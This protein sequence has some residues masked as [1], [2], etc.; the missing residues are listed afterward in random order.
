MI[1]RINE[2]IKALDAVADALRKPEARVLLTMAAAL[3]LLQMLSLSF[4]IVGAA[5]GA[6]LALSVVELWRGR[7]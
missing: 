3:H 4:S 2:A 6:A 1:G 7:L 5:A